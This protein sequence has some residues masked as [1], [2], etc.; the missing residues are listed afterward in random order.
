[1]LAS[2][3][4]KSLTTQEVLTCLSLVGVLLHCPAVWQGK[5]KRLDTLHKGCN[6]PLL[7]AGVFR[8][9]RE[10]PLLT[11]RVV[12][13]PSN[14]Q[15]QHQYLTADHRVHQHSHLARSTLS[16]SLLTE[17]CKRTAKQNRPSLPLPL[18]HFAQHHLVQGTCSSLASG[19]LVLAR[20]HILLL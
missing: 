6:Q 8:S 4:P 13:N 3:H 18:M 14:S 9:R 15:S 11:I 1:M 12:S 16:Q 5:Q 20:R 10:R 19:D 2:T 7:V 17:A